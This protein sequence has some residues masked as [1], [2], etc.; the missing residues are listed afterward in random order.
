[1]FAAEE[2]SKFKIA[3]EIFFPLQKNVEIFCIASI[4]QLGEVYDLKRKTEDIIFLNIKI[5][6]KKVIGYTFCV[7]DI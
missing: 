7:R 5:D 4:V 2:N 1:L 6:G 3:A